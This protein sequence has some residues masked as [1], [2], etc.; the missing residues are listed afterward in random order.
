[1]A[2]KL[3]LQV[4]LDT[5]DRATRPLKKIT[6]GSG[7]TA[8]ALKAS[9]DQLRHLERAQK[10]LRGFRNLKR[11][12]ET[13]SR[14]LE[15]QQQEIRDLSR[16][17]KNAEGDTSA[18]T[19]KRDAAIRQARR[20]SQ[21]YEN[22][23]RQLQQLR[24]NMTR[25]DGVTGKFSDQ[26]RELQRRIQ[27]ANQEM[28]QQQRHL[29]EIA[30]KQRLAADASRQFHRGMGRAGRMQGAGAGGLATGGAALYAGARMLAPGID[31]GAQMSAVQAV[32]RF[33]K[34]DPRFQ[35][36]KEQ[37]RE[38]GASTAFSAT[39]VG[40]GQEF[41]LRA[42]MS[43]EAIKASMGDVLSLALANN[44]ELGRAADIASNIAGTFKID[45]E[46]EGSMGRVA[47]I[48]SGSASRANV[49]LEM[50]GET[51][52]YL[53]GAEDLDLTMEQA[54][55][56][57]GLMGNIGIQG[58]QAGTAMRAMMNRLTAPAKEGADAMAAI[59]LQVADANGNMRAMPDILR[60]INAATAD[61]GNV[62]R[63]AILQK[64]FG[65]EAGSGM[66]ELVN[67]MSSGKLDELIASLGENYGENAR[68]A[69]T[70]SDNIK[71]D[72]K[73]LGSAWAE[74]GI[75][76]TETNEGPLRG[77][78]QM[79]TEVTR[80][81]GAWMNENPEL[82]AQIA[83]VVAG[84]AGL[85]AAGGA[86]TLALGSLL[87]PIVLT[88]YGL[89]MM[90]IKGGGLGK[91]LKSIATRAIPV[92][93]G[94]LRMLGAAAMANPILA[95]ASLIAAAALYIWTNWETLGPKFMAL[96]QGIQD[97][98]GAAW[99][100]IKAA[101]EGGI[102]GVSRLI[103][104]WS[105]AGLIWR[106]ITAALQQLGIDV[107][108]G[109]TSLGSAIIDGMIGGITGGLGR[110]GDTVTNMAGSV[111]SWFK[112]KLGINSPSR[113]FAEF[114]GNLLEGLINGI[115]ASWQTLRDAIGNTADAVV[116]WFKDKLGIHSPSRVF[117]ELG[118]HTMDGY[119]QGVQRSER[120]PLAEI[121]AFAKRIT[122]AGAGIALGAFGTTVATAG[123][124]DTATIT[125]VPIDHRPPLSSVGSGDVTITI[126]DIN[127]Y[128]SPGMDEQALAR[129]VA[130]EVQR[131]L[132]RAARE[133][134]A[135]R[136]S[137]FHDTE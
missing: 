121:A 56:M 57:A 28:Q 118:G 71:G 14:A 131:A 88:R 12:A 20:L 117:A 72:L 39:E 101:F 58:S 122:Q 80:S 91:V 135:R 54:A 61:L 26:Q 95:I 136:R 18:L 130:A 129:Y 33:E 40:A 85:V 4:I 21:Q 32:G 100:G 53:G 81:I 41:L 103:L 82:T 134:S 64:I 49:D 97:I 30:R 17:L 3:S 110:L 16:Q 76:L 69:A 23:Q 44:T 46:A 132:E 106:G 55:A 133:Q 93:I 24:T 73:G 126:G 45:M 92:V 74:I 99:E 52:K 83:T 38:L 67:G 60:D 137:A 127:V 114:G 78:V 1:M 35:A 89:E 50:L 124:L 22:E 90:G 84:V 125:D 19:R 6:Q 112:E 2:N 75:T 51:M 120:G 5:V 62:E 43:A 79:V 47:D 116:G 10:D 113:V 48:L 9:R 29:G 31:Y 34:N 111:V 15:Q 68:M 77:L 36:L 37:S 105:P 59:G 87:G 98:L 25:V 11:Q 70:M 63:K 7:K 119:Q 8:E 115:D 108:A 109:F 123:V 86:L 65:A 27:Q 128:P 42:G 66:A 104:D 102:A 96:W 107:P 13:S 94:A